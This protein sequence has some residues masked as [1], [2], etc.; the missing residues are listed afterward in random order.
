MKYKIIFSKQF[1]VPLIVLT[2]ILIYLIL[3]FSGQTLIANLVILSVII[4]GSY[5][6]F[7]DTIKKLAKNRFALD[8]IAIVALLVALYTQE[9]LVAA[10]LALM[11]SSG[12]T[13]ENYAV[14]QAKKSLTSLIDRIPS[15]VLLWE[16]EKAGEKV[17]VKDVKV[18]QLI[19][20]RVGEVIP[21]DGILI[22]ET[23]QTDESSLTGEPYFIDK[24]KGD[25]L[26]SGTV[27]IGNPIVIKVTKTEGNS[28]YSKII[29]L[30]KKA[31]EEQSPFV[32]LADRY[33]AVFTAITFVI[34]SFALISS[35]FDLTRVLAVLAIA[36]PCPLIIATP[37]ALL[38]GVSSAA[39]RKIIIKKLACLESL[40]KVNTIVFDKTG[41]ITLGKPKLAEIMLLTKQFTKQQVLS[42]AE[43]LERNSL[44][45]LAKAIVIKARSNNAPIQHATNVAETI[46]HGISG[47]VGK[48]KF[49]LSKMEDDTDGICIE[50][51]SDKKKT[52]IF[53]FEDEL[54]T[55]SQKSFAT[56]KS[57]G[58]DLKVFTGDKQL[59]A[60]K[61]MQQLNLDL[62][63]RAQ[64]SPEDKLAG[65]KELQKS[66]KVV[67][68]IGDGINDAPALAQANVGLVFSNEEQTS[69]SEAA[70][71]VFLGG[72]ISQVVNSLQIAKK[73]IKIALQ[74]IGF[75][76][77]LSTL[78]M[79]LASFGYIPPIFGAGLQ[80]L[81]DVAVIINAL[82]ASI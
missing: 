8:Y 81:I 19:F 28:T 2:G 4:L 29:E 23:G 35:N 24:I 73:T 43:S 50:L 41:T 21:L 3:K 30:V 15:D 68:M 22:S 70:D 11:L 53:K 26:R 51:T 55:D 34:A 48:E 33:S 59:A 56:L 39:K 61:I 16:K 78:G 66:G 46:G 14:S 72:E 12:R 25:I 13:L 62:E 82:R 54:K 6:L 1:R 65:I 63:I 69:S 79:I 27:N 64:M 20:I 38:G 10:I 45:P 52:A 44:H 36:T 7:F 32:R 40:A 80:E 76:I 60:E 58:L 57:L 9:F 42:I 71:I 77:G 75:G 37:V 49:S 31:Q 17:K 18:G 47:M 67:A 5:Q 74:S